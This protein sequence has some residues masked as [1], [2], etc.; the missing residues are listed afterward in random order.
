MEETLGISVEPLSR[1]EARSQRLSTVADAGG[2]ML[3]TDVAE[4]GPA[5]RRI[6]PSEQGPD[7]I[8]SVEGKPVRTRAEFREALK[9]VKA[10]DVVTLNVYNPRVGGERLVR[11][12]AR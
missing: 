12:R 9:G 4:D 5:Y 3:V 6:A 2:G 8:L 10:G 1:E 11:L 7:V